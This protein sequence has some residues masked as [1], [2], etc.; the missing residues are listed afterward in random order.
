MTPIALF[1]LG[2]LVGAVVATVG[3]LLWAY[4]SMQS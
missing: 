2:V 3:W 4:R 1:T